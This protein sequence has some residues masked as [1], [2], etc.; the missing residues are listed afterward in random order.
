LGIPAHALI[1]GASGYTTWWK[2][3]GVFVQ[4]ARRIGTIR[5]DL[6]VHFVW[7]GRKFIDQKSAEVEHD[8]RALGL[9]DRVHFIGERDNP[10]DYYRTFDIFAMVSREDSFPLV[11]LE[12][13]ALGKPIVCFDGAG[14][15]SELVE[16]DAG[17][18]VPYLD[19]PAM[20][21]RVVALLDDPTLRERL[22]GRAAAKVLG[23]HQIS[24]AAPQLLTIIQETMRLPRAVAPAV[25]ARLAATREDAAAPRVTVV[26][27]CFNQ[28]AYIDDAINSVLAQ[29]FQDFEIIVVDDGST[30]PATIERLRDYQRPKTRVVRTENHGPSAAR[31][32]GISLGTGEYILPLDADDRIAATYL[33][34]G[35]EALDA[36][37][38]VG[39]VYGRTE[40]FGARTGLV[41]GAGFDLHEILFSNTIVVTALFRRKDWRAAGGY[42]VNMTEGFE[43]WDFWLTLLEQGREVSLLPETLF[44]YRVSD[45]SRNATLHGSS[46]R[47]QRMRRAAM[48]NHLLLYAAH[49]D[50]LVWRR[51][52]LVGLEDAVARVAVA[53]LTSRSTPRGWARHKAFAA[54]LLAWA[55]YSRMFTPTTRPPKPVPTP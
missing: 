50:A 25:A 1:V 21:D 5:P 51:R 29:T 11:C 27:P 54:T 34:R 46:E 53:A 10:F 35:I 41:P 39:I 38:G 33:R 16:D 47:L 45:T 44:F 23:R 13:A 4:L 15:T 36:R 2:A 19:V 28:G 26:I 31:N 42:A 43:D 22:G 40:M 24:N 37:P 17:Y 9:G 18:V 3:P 20:A 48:L 8:V 14:G 49:P 32:L 7:V 12:S 52:D 55:A 6:P 30:D